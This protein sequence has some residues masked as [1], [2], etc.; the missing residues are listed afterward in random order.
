MTEPAETTR[1]PRALLRTA[2]ML[3]MGAWA[4][5]RQVDA[6]ISLGFD[7]LAEAW[8]H[9]MASVADD[10]LDILRD[11]HDERERFKY[12]LDQVPALA[13]LLADYPDGRKLLRFLG[14]PAHDRPSPGAD[15]IADPHDLDAESYGPEAERVWRNTKAL[16]VGA[17][18]LD[19]E[20][21]KYQSSHFSSV[22]KQYSNGL[23]RTAVAIVR[24]ASDDVIPFFA[25][26][27]A[28]GELV[29]EE[30][31]AYLQAVLPLMEDRARRMSLVV[32]EVP[33]DRGGP[34]DP[35]TGLLQ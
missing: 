13:D 25:E 26:N 11:D 20:A 12:S 34:A 24:E 30:A 5:L 6:E 31:G 10:Y 18:E 19:S 2:D 23:R 4:L 28:A 16:L 3:Y 1:G 9:E 14:R 32:D 22:V 35:E 27:S 21:L 8:A 15:T 17:R 29:R 7:L 33:G